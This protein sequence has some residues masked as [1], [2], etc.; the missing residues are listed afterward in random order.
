[1][2]KFDTITTSFNSGELSPKL[3]VRT[4]LNQFKSGAKT[5][6]NVELLAQGG[7]KRRG[8]FRLINLITNNFVAPNITDLDFNIFKFE[9]RK[10]LELQILFY[11]VEDTVYLRLYK[12]ENTG[13]TITYVTGVNNNFNVKDIK[14][15]QN[16]NNFVVTH[17]DVN[18][19][20]L[21]LKDDTG[22]NTTFNDIN[23]VNIPQLSFFDDLSPETI[24]EIQSIYISL[25]N[26]IGNSEGKV[27]GVSSRER[28]YKFSFN[29]ELSEEIDYFSLYNIE[30]E[31]F[32]YTWMGQQITVPAFKY[33][34]DPDSLECNIVNTIII[35]EDE[36]E[37]VNF[38]IRNNQS[39]I[40]LNI[41]SISRSSFA[42]DEDYVNNIIQKM[43][44]KILSFFGISDF[45][46]TQ[47]QF[48]LV[49]GSIQG[50][51]ATNDLKFNYEIK[52][53][54]H[55]DSVNQ[56]FYFTCA[57]FKLFSDNSNSSFVSSVGNSLEKM[58]GLNVLRF[59]S[60]FSKFTF[61]KDFKNNFKVF[62]YNSLLAEKQVETSNADNKIRGC[63]ETFGFQID[64]TDS[65][66]YSK[67]AG[68][69]I[70]A[71][72]WQYETTIIRGYRATTGFSGSEDVWSDLRGYPS[73]SAF[74]ENRLVFGGSK[75]LPNFLWA[76]KTGDFF[77]F[78]NTDNL[79][80]EAIINVSANSTTLSDIKFVTGD[81]SLQV[82]TEGG[83]HYNPNALTPSSI[84]LPQQSNE[85]CA[86]IAPVL[87]DNATYF[88]NKNKDTLRRFLYDDNEQSYK[89]ENVSILSSHLIKNP[90]DMTA[91]NN[92]DSNF[93]V[94]VNED[95]TITVLQ[96]IREQN[97]SG[98]FRWESDVIKFVA[99]T[100]SGGELYAVGKY[101]IENSVFYGL[102]KYDTNTALDF[103]ELKSNNIGLKT[104]L[105]LY[106]TIIKDEDN[107]TKYVIDNKVNYSQVTEDIEVDGEDIYIGVD[108]VPEVE[109]T[110]IAVNF[111]TGEKMS[112]K[113]RI[114]EAFLHLDYATSWNLTYKQKE[115]KI[116][117][118]QGSGLN[119]IP[120]KFTGDKRVKLMGYIENDTIKITQ[121]Q[122]FNNGSVLGLTISIKV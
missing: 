49:S 106:S 118:R 25:D 8:G 20:L 71:K 104:S 96:T 101:I 6:K 74:V 115:Y 60:A 7:F 119:E 87:I 109:T 90:I 38:K 67:I 14:V 110:A 48:E 77:N 100:E 2:P 59:Y 92:S 68:E 39:G 75:S 89:A 33:Y 97:I 23:F 113:K 12:D 58:P 65:D 10:G 84:S 69:F 19:K 98:Y 116:D 16:V 83:E 40:E 44:E 88:I 31:S 37:L 117:Y 3:A 72:K 62:P 22:N 50:S 18:P 81:K 34:I 111:G 91:F 73:S 63:G 54:E 82:F 57:D 1:M 52:N 5:A 15:S 103:E 9:V 114:N 105:N 55:T 66:S 99:V 78:S 21:R 24:P 51:F 121:D 108:F 17:P 26:V 11:K 47:Y 70:E 56:Y 27:T 35:N 30:D 112:R 13:S 36:N 28:T 102:F 93:I 46:T 85:G 61:F 41:G 29:G 64:G 53:I 86:N 32:N 43:N 45:F 80:D 76:S 95:N 94:I 79:P 122:P 120:D 4:D 107:Y 42:T